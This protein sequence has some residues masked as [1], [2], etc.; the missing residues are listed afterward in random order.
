M[1]L[2]FFVYAAFVALGVL[3]CGNCLWSRMTR[4]S[5]SS[6]LA[7][8]AH[9]L[10]ENVALTWGISWFIGYF[11][12]E[13]ILSL[14]LM[15]QLFQPGIVVITGVVLSCLGIFW[16]LRQKRDICR[17]L[18]DRSS[19][20]LEI[21]LL[22][23]MALFVLFWNLYPAFDVDSLA[24][25]FTAI[26]QFLEK[27]GRFFSPFSDIRHSVPLGENYLYAL[28]FA[29][30]SQSTIFPQLLHGFSKVMFLMCVYGVAKSLGA[31]FF[32]L[33]A[34]ALVLS[35]EHLLASGANMFVRIN[36]SLTFSLFLLCVSLLLL[37]RTQRHH[38]AALA[39]A[40]GCY[41]MLCKYLGIAYFLCGA[42]IFF[43]I[44]LARKG[45]GKTFRDVLSFKRKPF[46]MSIVAASAVFAALPYLYNYI[47]TGTPVFPAA[48]GPFQSPHY[49]SVASEISRLWHYHL[50]LPQV[51]KN[52]TAFMVWP[53]ILPSKILTPVALLASVFT[54][55][56][57]KDNMAH[58]KTG[59]AFLLTSIGVITLNG[60]Y[61]VFE[62]RYYRYGIGMYAL[63][64]T[65]LLLFLLRSVFGQNLWLQRSQ[66]IAG[67]VFV[68]LVCGFCVSYSFNVM[69]ASRPSA[70]EIIAFVSNQVSEEDI[71][72]QRY[73]K[74]FAQYRR[75][76][77]QNLP[78]EKMAFLLSFSWPHTL[79]PVA[80]K[81]IAFLHSAAFPSDVYY[82]DGL[83]AKALLKNNVKYVFNQL[84]SEKGYPLE[85]RSVYHVLDQCGQSLTQDGEDILELSESCL[86]DL[87][88][89]PD[90]AQAQQSL[91]QALG[92][93]RSYP[94]YDPFNPPA[95]GGPFA[96]I[97]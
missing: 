47:V 84:V 82:N 33:V 44:L 91:Q 38:F 73:P 80:G 85:G 59:M 76:M 37:H 64:C 60:L 41:A 40:A 57:G 13:G 3:G 90:K 58:F 66:N 10:T 51:L 65:F 75:L 28:G 56:A 74:A 62:M 20:W 30:R 16:L 71:V 43:L 23:A 34:A 15:C 72:A 35:E 68:V 49:D 39:F 14:L 86:R 29:V 12:Y 55:L 93:I 31:G 81:D 95:Y 8:A 54:I 97:K 88:A 87:A 5:R 2:M 27:G 52:I 17:A 92:K 22:G 96:V 45:T 67:R 32:S 70:K 1:F 94:E 79:Y 77:L 78:N 89:A 24:F 18:F 11:F 4:E 61:M 26:Q 69:G 21:F 83:F 25:Y 50:S 9:P 36:T 7:P 53:G 46:T 48:V 42:A 19:P 6:A 63:A